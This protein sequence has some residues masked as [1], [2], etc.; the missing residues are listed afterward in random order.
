MPGTWLVVRGSNGPGRRAQMSLAAPR[1]HS[2]ERMSDRA[3]V[4][5]PFGWSEVQSGG[6]GT[7]ASVAVRIF[8]V[9]GRVLPPAFAGGASGRTSCLW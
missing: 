1:N 6:P 4:R 9:V 7:D 3:R 5:Q 2:E 8:R